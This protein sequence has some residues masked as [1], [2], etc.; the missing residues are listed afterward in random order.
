MARLLGPGPGAAAERRH[1]R[2][3]YVA[4]EEACGLIESRSGRHL[5]TDEGKRWRFSTASRQ[6]LLDRL[7][8]LTAWATR[9]RK[10]P[11]LSEAL[12]VAE[13]ARAGRCARPMGVRERSTADT[14]QKTRSRRRKR[15]NCDRRPRGWRPSVRA[16]ADRRTVPQI[17][18]ARKDA[19]RAA[20]TPPALSRL[21][22]HV[23]GG[24]NSRCRE[25][26]KRR[27]RAG[28]VAA[29]GF[30]ALASSSGG[31]AAGSVNVRRWRPRCEG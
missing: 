25:A 2:R 5:A 19:E 24:S 31:A 11:R 30:E 4:A 17:L 28:S 22:F 26:C 7:I 23:P 20:V 21:V 9:L 1:P 16:V 15:R 29:V 10:R 13:R 14:V 3:R 27:R 8:R 6:V 12:G 18:G